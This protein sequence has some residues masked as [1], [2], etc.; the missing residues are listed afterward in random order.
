[1]ENI[2]SYYIDNS[3][4]RPGSE[5]KKETNRRGETTPFMSRIQPYRKLYGGWSA[6]NP[7]NKTSFSTFVRQKPL[8]VVKPQRASDLCDYCLDQPKVESQLTEYRKRAGINSQEFID[9]I[10]GSFLQQWN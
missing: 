3:R 9:L 7:E 5:C 1:M 2:K 8:N 6:E 10:N 4:I